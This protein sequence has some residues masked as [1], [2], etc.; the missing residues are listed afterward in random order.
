MTQAT[1]HANRHLHHKGGEHMGPQGYWLG[2][3]RFYFHLVLSYSSG[4][5]PSG[6][7]GISIILGSSP[8]HCWIQMCSLELPNSSIPDLC[9]DEVT[10][11]QTTIHAKGGRR[12]YFKGRAPS[13]AENVNC[14]YLDFSTQFPKLSQGDEIQQP[15]KTQGHEMDK[16]HKRRAQCVCCLRCVHCIRIVSVRGLDS[17]NLGIS[18]LIT[19]SESSSGWESRSTLCSAVCY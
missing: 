16:S 14:S 8:I 17:R 3:S 9:R 10:V 7:K 18:G 2:K 19:L 11:N 6:V 13:L 5:N 12:G 4:R 15:H 1:I